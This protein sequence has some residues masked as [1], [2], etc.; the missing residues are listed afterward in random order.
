MKLLPYFILLLVP[1]WIN[2]QNAIS[3]LGK[4]TDKASGE[5][6]PYATIQLLGTSIG[7]TT[8]QAGDFVFRIPATLPTP[9]VVFSC[10]GYRSIKLDFI[11]GD[12]P[13][14]AIALEPEPVQLK[15]VVVK[16]VD[17]LQVIATSLERVA[18]NYATA[19]YKAEGFQREYVKAD[20]SV[21]QLLEVAFRT[22]G[23]AQS[24]A[25]TVLDAWY[26]EDKRAK[27][28]FW[29]PS[30]GGFY[31]FGGTSISGIELPGPTAF[32][33]IELKKRSDLS[34]YYTF[35]FRGMS[36]LDGKEVFVIDFDQKKQVRKPFL[37]GTLYIDAGSYAIIR[38]EHLVSPN[39]L[40][41][42]KTHQTWGG[43]TIS[44]APK[45][46]TV[47]QDRWVTTYKQ[48]GEKWYLSSVVIDTEFSAAL[49]FMGLVQARQDQLRLHSERIVTHL[50]TTH[51]PDDSAGTYIAD[52]GKLPTLQNFIKKNYENKVATW[53][54]LNYL[55]PDT[56]LAGLAHQIRR[57]NERWEVELRKRTAEKYLTS[58]AL[59]ARQLTDDLDYLRESLEG[60]H[61]GLY[62]YTDKASLD[63]A[64]EQL[65]SKLP[66]TAS[67]AEF[68]RLLSPVIEQIHCGHTTL[69]PSTT[70]EEYQAQ[71][72]K[73]FPLELRLLGDSTVISQDYEG[74]P[75]GS[76][77]LAINGH[78]QAEV[79]RRIQAT[80]P[81][82]G[83]N[84]T[85]KQFRLQHD[86]P[87]LFVR[88][89]QPADTF[90]VKIRD[91]DQQ[92]RTIRLAGSDRSTTTTSDHATTQLHDS[93]QT[94]VLKIPSF[95]TSQDFP[96]FVDETF[97]KIREQQITSLVIDLRDNQGGRDDYGALLYSYLAQEPFKYYR[98]ISVATTDSS[99]LNRLSVDDVPLLKAL[100]KYPT[101]IQKTDQGYSYT[102]H[103]NL[104][105]QQ[106]RQNAYSGTVYFLINGG[107]FSSA[108]EFVAIARSHKRGTFIGQETG[109]GYYGNSSLATSMLTLPNSKLRL[110][111]PLGRYA[112]AVST[113]GAGGRGVLPDHS[114][115]YYLEDVI[116]NRDKELEY[117]LDLIN[118]IKK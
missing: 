117:C 107:T 83:F 71:F 3:L 87:S 65:L 38:L 75:R 63:R 29:N 40:R 6:I 86:F 50:D 111:M 109:G 28:P 27:A 90:E 32:L 94:L 80:I 76:T 20:S 39:G 112:L 55:K 66:K 73:R 79:I 15:E 114:M 110:T 77:V 34:R 14:L 51:I 98:Q 43:M 1:L 2:A 62:W 25:T 84:Q 81:S 97:L 41:H 64:F 106:P 11:K 8:N 26:L 74:I 18:H 67:E 13:L 45:R 113:D 118:K 23:T 96:D 116:N 42:L 59:T 78:D 100:P 68:F 24:Q 108:A 19:P 92:I 52:V 30:R 103:P 95:A 22:V 82:D 16:P 10:L 88:Y 46:L 102:H 44:T 37:K 49:A 31:T 61:P 58:R 89:I 60:I 91:K 54:H 17:P 12:Q 115:T 104:A 85:Y 33:G 21:I 101:H 56:A 72:T 35:E 5:A 9:V 48:Y 93:L 99:L 36:H 7:T 57:N 105:F 69:H 53:E 47:Q 70:T 4:V